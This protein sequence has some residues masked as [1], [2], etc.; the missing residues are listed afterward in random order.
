MSPHRLLLPLLLT[1]L[2][3]ACDSSGEEPGRFEATVTGDVATELV[4]TAVLA[5]HTPDDLPEPDEPRLFLELVDAS[6]GFILSSRP[7]SVPL[8]EGTYPVAFVSGDPEAFSGSISFGEVGP[9]PPDAFLAHSGTLTVSRVSEE[10]AEGTFTFVAEGALDE[11]R[12]VSV[13]G[14]FSARRR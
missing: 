8:M 5:V 9:T 2:C 3:L 4:G 7:A 14:T 12:Q 11:T 1:F 13:E 6:K 10:V